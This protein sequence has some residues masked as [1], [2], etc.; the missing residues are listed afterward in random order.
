[1]LG[2]ASSLWWAC[3]F[4]ILGHAGT[5]LCWVYSTTMLHEMTEDRFRGRVFSAD[6]A[7]LFLVMSAVSFA[8]ASLIDAGVNVRYVALGTGI[9]GVL[10]ALLWLGALRRYFKD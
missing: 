10:P 6:Y 1:A 5:S 4:V 3:A 7:G 8:A 9:I 2:G